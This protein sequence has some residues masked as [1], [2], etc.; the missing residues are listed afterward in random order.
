MNACQHQMDVKVIAKEK[1]ILNIV[2]VLPLFAFNSL[3][4]L[5]C[6]TTFA[7]CPVIVSYSK[8]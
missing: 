7:S 6:R 5:F 1:I 2:S 3:T 8:N 4:S